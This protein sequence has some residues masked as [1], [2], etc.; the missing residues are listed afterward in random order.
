V[1]GELRKREEERK[2]VE[3]A[4]VGAARAAVVEWRGAGLRACCLAQK[5][6]LV[7]GVLRFVG[8]RAICAAIS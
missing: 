6:G 1:G 4:E 5:V 2:S 3:R 8:D 7:G